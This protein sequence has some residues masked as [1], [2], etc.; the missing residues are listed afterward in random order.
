MHELIRTNDAVLLSFAQSLM[1]DAGIESLIADQSMSILEGSLGLLPRR[2]LVEPGRA[3]EAR[4][5]L[6]DAGLGAE[7]R[8]GTA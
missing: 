8:D 3:E 5:I 4:R 2:F 7:L 1:K 6:I